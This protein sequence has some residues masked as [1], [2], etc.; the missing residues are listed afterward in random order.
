MHRRAGAPGGARPNVTLF[1]PR[2]E[3]GK[4][5]IDVALSLLSLPIALP[6]MIVC[7]TAIWL[8]DGR[9]MIFAQ[10][11]TGR[12]GERF[13]LYK[14]RTMVVD[15]ATLKSRYRHLNRLTGPD[16]KIDSDPR[17]TRLG[18]LLR[19]SSLDELPQLFNVLKGEMSLVGPRP[20]SFEAS[21]YSLWHTERLEVTPGLTG[22]WQV[23][24]RS[25]VDFDQRVRLDVEYIENRSLATDLRILLQT[26]KALLE[27]RGAY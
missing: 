2:Y 7:A 27:R 18:N 20:T 24:G 3:R 6:L 19:R 12:G 13:H 14:F 23:S 1:A 25:D 4:R 26:P 5:I 11:R 10:L 17:V 9:P 16:F 8:T 15:A 21:T 22:L